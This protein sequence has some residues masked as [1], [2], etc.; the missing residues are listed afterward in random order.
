MNADKAAQAFHISEPTPENAG[1]S[2]ASLDIKRLIAHC[3]GYKGA[4]AKR[5]VIQL[6]G[7]VFLFFST[8]AIMLGAFYAH[9]YWACALLVLPAAGLLIRLF[10]IQHDCGHGSFFPSTRANNITGRVLSILTF[11][12]YDLWKR[13]HNMHHASSG[14]LSRRTV[15]AIDT[16][17]VKEYQALSAR[18]R[19]S[20]RLFRNPFLLLL[21]AP[22]IY[23]IILQR[24][25]LLQ[26]LPFLKDYRSIPPAQA[27]RSVV[28]TDA[29]ILVFY[30]IAGACLG[31]L[32]M[33]AVVLPVVVVSCW[34][35]GWLFFIQHQFEDAYWEQGENWSFAEAAVLGSSHYVLPPILMWFTGNIGLHHIHHLCA[36]IPNY[37]LQECFASD[38]ELQEINRMTLRQ[39]LKCIRWALWDEEKS[40]MIGFRDLQVA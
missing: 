23:M 19:K 24:F 10:I 7:A 37:R 26:S 13:A 17:T 38:R 14:N 40:K 34:I 9:L 28:A 8:I 22:P 36:M 25:P 31:W 33:L 29:A 32:A 11:T 35:G 21:L 6:S 12:P 3:H 2:R 39:S 30:G 1:R 20:Y 27:W 4:D 5:G 18:E 15:G 16:L